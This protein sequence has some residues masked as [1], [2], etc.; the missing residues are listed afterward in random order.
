MTETFRV[1]EL[2][3]EVRRSPRRRTLELTVDRSGE[4]VMRAPLGT[5]CDEL[6][7]WART[8]LLWVHRKLAVKQ[9]SAPRV[10]D[11]EYVTGETFS[12]LGKRYRLELVGSQNQALRF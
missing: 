7:A 10:R 11:P 8:K 1:G 6:L 12:Y 9:E 4:L 5:G 3:F 2:I